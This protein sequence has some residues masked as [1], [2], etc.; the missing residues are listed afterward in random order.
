MNR[1]KT[2][3]LTFAV[4][5]LSIAIVSVIS[6]QSVKAWTAPQPGPAYNHW[7]SGWDQ[8]QND[9]YYDA[10]NGQY[11]DYQS[12]ADCQGHTHSYCDGYIAGYGDYVSRNSH[13]LVDQQN[14]AEN[15][16]NVKIDGNNNRVEINQGQEQGNANGDSGNQ[17]QGGNGY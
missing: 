16:A 7:K 11:R 1:T 17:G 6:S 2:N 3:H 13:Q 15:N 9:A 5:I 14:V 10:S 8:A 4:A 12:G